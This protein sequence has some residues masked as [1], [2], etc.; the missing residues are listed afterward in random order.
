MRTHAIVLCLCL[1]AVVPGSSLADVVVTEMFHVDPG[2]EAG[3]YWELT[4]SNLTGSGIYMIA[5]GNTGA[6]LTVVRYPDLVG[7]WQPMRVS[8]DEWDTNDWPRQLAEFT[9][10]DTSLLPFA[11][12]FP[13][14]TQALVYYVIGSNP[15]LADGAVLTGLY[16]NY[17]IGMRSA[18][19]RAVNSSAGSPFLVFG[20]S[21]EV[22]ARGQTVGTPLPARA[23][24]WGGIKALYR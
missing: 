10:P 17:P 14:H 1:A 7:I 11:T 16:F 9:T 18:S 21:G 13:G 19:G 8:Q 2:W 23:S 3:G 4:V 12:E 22:V 5:V 24:T 6:D 15:P 20:S